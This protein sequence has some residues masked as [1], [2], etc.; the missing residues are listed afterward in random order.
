MLSSQ[1]ADQFA[2]HL[3]PHLGSI[4]RCAFQ[5]ASSEQQDRLL[6]VQHENLHREHIYNIVITSCFISGNLNLS[7]P[8]KQHHLLRQ[9]CEG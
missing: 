4:L 9:K 1:H 8:E 2:A 6:K 3:L 5:G 7:I